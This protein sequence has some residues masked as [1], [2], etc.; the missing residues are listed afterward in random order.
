M[1]DDT[2]AG[3]GIEWLYELLQDT[4]LEQFL[5]RIRDDLQVTRLAH[6]DYVQAE[7]LEKIGMGKPAARR[8]LEAVKKRKTQLWK[9]NLLTKLMPASSHKTSN[10]GTVGKKAQNQE[11][12]GL[13]L[14][15]LIQ[16]KDVS[17]SVK[18]G[19]GSFGVVRKGEWTTPAGRLMPVAVKVLKQDALS[20]PGVFEDFVKEVQAMHQLDHPQLIRLYGVVL[21]QPMMMVTELASLG[22]LLDYL[23]K[24]CA[25][26]PINT[27]WDYS[28]Q[29]ATGMAYLETKRFIHRDL[30]CRNVL[31]ASAD[32]IKI[33]DFGL[34]RALPQAED[35]YV[36][37]EHSKVP[38]PWCAP[39][40]LK[41]RQFSHA[42]DVW[43][44]G[45]TVWEMF[46]FGEEPWLGLNGTQILRKIDRE[47]ERLRQPE[48][49]SPELYRLMLQCWNKVPA[50]RPTFSAI[51]EFLLKSHPPV[52][53][54]LQQH[55]EP[56]KLSIEPG[57][58]VA[59]I[60]GRP[61]LYWW[62]GQNLRT[63]DIGQFPRCVVDPMRRKEP[64]DISKPL[65]NSF[66]HTGHGDPY[67]QSWGS[68]AEIDEVYLRNPMDP[69]DLLGLPTESTPGPPVTPERKRRSPHI[70]ARHAANKQFNYMKL[71]NEQQNTNV[72]DHRV[73]RPAPGRPPDPV[74]RDVNGTPEAVLIDFS[75]D[76]L[77]LSVPA[78]FSNNL[79][80]NSTRNNNSSSSCILD[81]PIDV[82]EADDDYWSASESFTMESRSYA[83][84]PHDEVSGSGGVGWQQRSGSPDPFDTSRPFDTGGA[85][86][87]YS[88][89][90]PER[91]MVLPDSTNTN[92][93][94]V[95]NQSLYSN[96]N[97]VSNDSELIKSPVKMLDPKFIA[98]LEK[99]LGK[100][101]ASANMDN[102]MM[103]N[104]KS[105]SLGESNG[106]GIPVLRP[107][108][109][110]SKSL[111]RKPSN[112][113]V[114]SPLP[115]GSVLQNSWSSK[116]VNL[117]LDVNG[118]R[119]SRSQSVCLPSNPNMVWSD[120]NLA[121][122]NQQ[123]STKDFRY[124]NLV[125]HH[126]THDALYSSVQNVNSCDVN[127]RNYS[128][129]DKLSYQQNLSESEALF[130]KMWISDS[131]QYVNSSDRRQRTSSSG[132]GIQVYPNRVANRTVSVPVTVTTTTA[133]QQQRHMY[134]PVDSS[135]SQY[136]P[137]GNV[138][139]TQQHPATYDTNDSRNTESMFREDK[140][141]QMMAHLG[142][143]SILQ[144]EECLASLQENN[145]DI[146][147]ALRQVKLNSLL[148]LGVAS[149]YQCEV[150]LEKCDWNVDQ[151]ASVILDSKEVTTDP[152][153]HKP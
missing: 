23:R 80:S 135:W 147:S 134:D 16:E 37:T 133:Q 75:S 47:G 81:E 74:H 19:D 114:P 122:H 104:S 142:G 98:E 8:L 111:Q 45:V 116:S 13:S 41:A 73:I 4:Q 65:K 121:M 125:N 14:T 33:G 2:A 128:S 5:S 61:D 117:R 72:R 42:S 89:V 132:S 139:S 20:Q 144:Q 123:A 21:T 53:K 148:R 32:K 97:S 151:A 35:C 24:Q 77:P 3:G 94:E 92:S 51:R 44:F 30:A 95:S 79:W 55:N 1:T 57:D 26:T 27:L 136:E 131:E 100:K 6:F 66:I 70:L 85:S 126:Y 105:S 102:S 18:L 7:D 137:V 60:D 36:M 140:V 106:G 152:T 40:S 120:P 107:P 110:S 118:A 145:W 59:I 91:A 11:S 84:Y 62:M 88:H 58:H 56:D 78:G 43:M 129:V 34:M 86:R 93:I 54:V 149:R 108:P 9:K 52:M 10:T 96:S 29:V 82:A 115:A 138:A 68:P 130:N 150:T 31:L 69:P 76:D 67:G 153:F 101:E 22:S 38:F 109:S 46:T 64:S 119:A 49:C 48:A 39:E 28:L 25:H 87:Y 141:K 90:T 127:S 12:I 99:H 15:C 143:D 113:T 124:G 146:P 50:D 103:S 63:F 112:V 83:N 17:L 71:S